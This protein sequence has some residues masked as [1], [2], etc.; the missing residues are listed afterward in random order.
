LKP[1]EAAVERKSQPE[2]DMVTLR[3][4]ADI[5]ALAVSTQD[6]EAGAAFAALRQKAQSKSSGGA[7]KAFFLHFAGTAQMKLSDGA[8]TTRAGPEIERL[9][10]EV[11]R[12][13]GKLSRV[14]A[15]HKWSQEMA[16]AVAKESA[17][18]EYELH[19]RRIENVALHQEVQALRSEI[20]SLTAEADWLLAERDSALE[21]KAHRKISD[22]FFPGDRRARRR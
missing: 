14:Q 20:T 17:A 16:A 12:L 22:A 8:D 18:K 9:T 5:L 4:V 11:E 15:A 1:W 6:G 10:Q 2:L 19:A 3:Q 13:N 7:V 21:A